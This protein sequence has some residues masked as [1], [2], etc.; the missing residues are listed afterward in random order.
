MT[1]EYAPDFKKGTNGGTIPRRIIHGDKSTLSCE[2]HENPEATAKWFFYKLNS[3]T[4]TS[5]DS[6]SKSLTLQNM[7]SFKR[8]IYECLIQNSIGNATKYFK[9]EHVPKGN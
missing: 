8:G 3:K 5:L 1:V 9:V 4:K 6:R 2:T 7:N